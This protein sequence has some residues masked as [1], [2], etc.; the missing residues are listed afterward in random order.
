MPLAP[1]RQLFECRYASAAVG[2]QSRAGCY[3]QQFRRFA[4]RGRSRK[5]LFKTSPNHDPMF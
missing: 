2:L 5:C 4:V 3:P 1:N